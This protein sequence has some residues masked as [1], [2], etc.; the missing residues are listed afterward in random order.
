MPIQAGL[1]YWKVNTWQGTAAGTA[2][3]RS[4]N[5]NQNIDSQTQ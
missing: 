2:R 3:N 4:V 5:W 1:P